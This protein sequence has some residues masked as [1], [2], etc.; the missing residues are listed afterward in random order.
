M[1]LK[2]NF[3][4]VIDG[5][6]GKFNSISGGGSTV[7]IASDWGGGGARKPRKSNGPVTFDDIELSRSFY[8][9][10]DDKWLATLRAA[11]YSGKLFCIKKSPLDANGVAVKGAKT[12]V[13]YNCM[14]SSLTEP[15]SEG[16]SEDLSTV[17]VSFANHGPA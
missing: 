5:I 4:V 14:I 13:Y 8:A 9:G 16:G 15:E 6:P 12:T 17:T 3:S 1:T 7:A 11:Q 10:A 2:H